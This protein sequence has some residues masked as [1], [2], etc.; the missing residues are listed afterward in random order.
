MAFPAILD[1]CALMG[2]YLC[3]AGLSIADADPYHPLWSVDILA[4]RSRDLAR[5]CVPEGAITHRI[6]AMQRAFP[7]AEVTG[8][9]ADPGDEL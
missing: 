7:D 3:D 1:T 6:G 4:E 5:L 8:R 9:G 2:G